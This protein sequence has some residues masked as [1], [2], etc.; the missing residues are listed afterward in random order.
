MDESER[1]DR[2]LRSSR[3]AVVGASTSRAKFG[4]KVFRAYLRHGIDAVPIHPRE[5]TIEG[6]V[7]Y[8]DLASVPGRIEAVSLITPPRIT[9]Q[10]VEQALARGMTHLWMQP[11]AE[12]PRAVDI[13]QRAGANVIFGGACVLVELPRRV[14]P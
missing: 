6:H 5:P 7:A 12:S 14:G 4:N 8:P 3:V 2:F 1:I 11:G 10:V 13:A 9:E